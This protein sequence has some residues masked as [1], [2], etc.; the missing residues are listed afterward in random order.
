M[1][2]SWSISRRLSA[3]FGIVIALVIALAAG[4]ALTSRSAGSGLT[5]YRA[6]TDE[7]KLLMEALEDFYEARIA[8]LLFLEEGEPALLDE[9]RANIAEIET[10]L[11]EIRS[12]GDDSPEIAAIG[13][14]VARFKAAFETRGTM[15]AAFAPAAAAHL[16]QTIETRHAISEL[17]DAA[18]PIDPA[19]ALTAARAS[20]QFL[21]ARVRADRAIAGADADTMESAA[22]AAAEADAALAEVAAQAPSAALRSAVPAMREGVAAFEARARALVERQAEMNALREN[23]V[24]PVAEALSEKIEGMTNIVVE[25]SRRVGVESETALAQGLA[26]SLAGSAV[27]ILIGLAAAWVCARSIG[28]AV[29]SQADAMARLAGGDLAVTVAGA[30]FQHELGAMA[31]ALETFRANA[32]QVARADAEAAAARTRMMGELQDAF[33]A[34]VESAVAGDFTARVS[35]RFPDAELNSLADGLNRLLET[36]E[37]GVAEAS[38]VVGRMAEG[39]LTATMAGAFSGAFAALQS[40]MNATVGKLSALVEEITTAAGDV[41]ASSGEIASGAAQVSQRAEQQAAALEETSATME[42]MTG[43]VRSNADNAAKAASLAD[44]TAKQAD[45]GQG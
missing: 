30:E 19:L 43:S 44:A 31:R 39:D 9:A 4:S 23:E 26:I 45:E 42:E 3:G 21:L 13:A 25:R 38:R 10:A 37:G 6:A 5:E 15:Q 12:A 1:L 32:Q 7:A 16:E 11:A 36:V 22:A 27:A 2:A 24:A 41:R 34:V 17:V 29:R 14:D 8:W 28:G 35:A 20:E 40:D 18:T 33:G